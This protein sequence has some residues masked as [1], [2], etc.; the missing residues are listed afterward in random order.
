M[1]RRGTFDPGCRTGPFEVIGQIFKVQEMNSNR[2]FTFRLERV[3]KR[4]HRSHGT[5]GSRSNDG[6]VTGNYF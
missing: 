4:R 2:R 6:I 5:G 1:N 3:E